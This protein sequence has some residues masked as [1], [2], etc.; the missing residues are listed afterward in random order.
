MPLVV[1]WL[2]VALLLLQAPGDAWTLVQSP[3]REIKRVYWDLFQTTEVWLRLVPEDRDGK[4]PLLSLVFHAFFPGPAERDPYSGLPRQPKGP[5]ARVVVRA[6]PL[7]LTM[8]RELSLRL[9]V[10]GNTVELTGPT[11]RY[12]N[13][14]CLIATEDCTPNA[15][16]ADLE[17]SVLRSLTIARTVRGEALG[18]PI[19]L[20]EADQAALSEFV[21]R[22]GLRDD[23]VLSK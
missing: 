22:I 8:I 11:S 3:P 5:P 19:R 14:P 15:V 13:L 9:V 21:T 2:P 16:E 17:P 20:T 1:C 12:R 6:Q 4:P 18:F 10:D 23:A 7:P